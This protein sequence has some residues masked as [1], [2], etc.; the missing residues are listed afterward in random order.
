MSTSERGSAA[1][2][3]GDGSLF[4]SFDAWADLLRSVDATAGRQGPSPGGPRPDALHY[5]PTLRSPMALVHVVDDGSEEGETFR[6]RE[7]LLTIGRSEGDIVIPHDISMSPRHACIE[8]F[9]TGGWQLS[10]LESAGGTFVRVT[11]AR[12]KH[13]SVIQLGRTRLCFQL[14]DLTEAWLVELQP[15]DQGQRHECHAPATSIGRAGGGCE[16]ALDDPF[17]SPTHAMVR[18]GPQGWRI[19]N[20]GM[21]GLWVRIEAPVKMNAPSQFQC[22]EQR[23]VFVPCGW[24]ASG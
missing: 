22:G 2:S 12:L 10:D 16:I 9:A 5:R 7:G 15:D 18:R 24:T 4:E 8:R 19:E 23:F 13:G 17:V 6:M 14:L 21:N 1:A 3:R 11:T 20:T